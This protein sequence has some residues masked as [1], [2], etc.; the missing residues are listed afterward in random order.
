[1]RHRRRTPLVLALLLLLLGS[2]APARPVAPPADL[3]GSFDRLLAQTYPPAEPGAAVLVEKDGQ[4]LLR[5]AYGLAHLELGVPLRPDMVF[6]IGSLTKQFTALAI[7][8][9]VQQGKLALS[10]DLTRFLPDYPTHGQRITIENLLT[11]TSGIKNYTDL[12]A[13]KDGSFEGFSVSQ[14]LDRVKD[15]PL[16]FAPGEKWLYDNSGYLLLGI[17][18]EKITGQPYA[19]WVAENLLKPLS[20]THTA[21]ADWGAIVPGRA[22]GYD[23]PTGHYRNALPLAGNQAQA[24]GGLLSTVDDLARWEHA[25][26]KGGLLRRDLLDRMFSPFHLKDGRSTNYGYGW[27][28]WTYEGHRLEE[29]DGVLNGFKSEILRLPEDHLLIVILSNALEHQ[30]SPATLAVRLAA[31]AIGKPLEERKTVPLAPEV[32]DRYVGMYQVDPTTSRMV[33][34][35]GDHLFTQRAGYPKLEILPAGGNEFFYRETMDRLRFVVDKDGKVTGMVLNRRYGGEEL[36]KRVP[37]SP[38]AG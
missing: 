38:P 30:P 21:Y 13:W 19:T 29:H 4:V 24:D 20:L 23:G 8:Q 2:S 25:L 31:Q 18:L 32:L 6:R 12:P 16:D 14:I 37:G 7:L 28:L 26:T 15:Q 33:S 27:E 22:A 34:R 5:K 3:A 36:A 9:Q 1:M 17:I 10:D 11:H 35:E